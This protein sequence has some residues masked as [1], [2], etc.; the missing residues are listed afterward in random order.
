M[1]NAATV[2][3]L[4]SAMIAGVTEQAHF[5]LVTVI[6]QQFTADPQRDAWLHWL[7]APQDRRRWPA[8]RPDARPNLSARLDGRRRAA[9]RSLSL[10]FSWHA[11]A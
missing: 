1:R 7:D 11:V 9:Q 8:A 10:D 3:R 6:C 4:W 5:H 2:T